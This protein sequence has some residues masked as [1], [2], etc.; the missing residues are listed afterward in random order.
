M[1]IPGRGLSGWCVIALKLQCRSLRF[2]AAS[3]AT[4][5]FMLGVLHLF[6]FQNLTR[7]K[8]EIDDI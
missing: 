3:G 7:A 8:Q 5:A 6:G 2:C 1:Y 4:S